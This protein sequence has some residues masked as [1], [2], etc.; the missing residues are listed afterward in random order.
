M[1]KILIFLLFLALVVIAGCAPETSSADLPLQ[2]SLST[3]ADSQMPA[4]T[5]ALTTTTASEA[6]LVVPPFRINI[7]TAPAHLPGEQIMF[8]IGITNLSSGTIT[9]DPFSPAMWIK[10][11]D[12][13]EIVYSSP[14]GQNAYDLQSDMPFLPNKDTWDQKDNN[15]QQVAPG[16]YEIGYEYVIIDQGTGKKYP[17]TPTARFQI[18]APDSAMNKN[19]D[20]NQSVTA[21]GVTVTLKRIEMNAVGTKVYTFTTP[22]EYILSTEHPPY[23][24]ESLI[25]NS[26][27][28]YSINGG[29]VKQVKS[30][31]GKADAEGVTLTWDNLE[32]MPLDAK[33]LTFVITQLGDLKGR[34]EFKIELN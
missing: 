26:T 7:S 33:E 21:E 22:P 2:S 24:M 19:L 10:S 23:Q 9:I 34:W 32:P 6:T 16:S 20:L 31:G 12:R 28:E 17:A 3:P 14:G 1:K 30:G 11:V 25:T 4:E 13:N 15:G 8:G 18:V 27:A 5:T 29:V